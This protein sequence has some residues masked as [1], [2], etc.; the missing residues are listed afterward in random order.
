M[1]ERA[2][3]TIR[4]ICLFSHTGFGTVGARSGTQRAYPIY[5]L[6]VFS[7][8]FESQLVRL[9]R[10]CCSRDVLVRAFKRLVST[11]VSVVQLLVSHTTNA[12]SS[13]HIEQY[14]KN[15]LLFLQNPSY[16]AYKYPPF[17]VYSDEFSTCIQIGNNIALH[18][19]RPPCV[20]LLIFRISACSVAE[21]SSPV[22]FLSFVHYMEPATVSL[23]R[24]LIPSLWLLRTVASARRGSKSSQ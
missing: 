10:C 11:Y 16:P 5:S 12:S 23:L 7:L 8:G 14:T 15:T 3:R 19:S 18:Q 22:P 1:R 21:W 9:P 6:F 4:G 20:N 13:K 24:C 2:W 17:S